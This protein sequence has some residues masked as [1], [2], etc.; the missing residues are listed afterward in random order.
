MD[1]NNNFNNNQNNNFNNN[2]N[3]NFNNNLNLSPE[4]YHYLNYAY[5][6]NDKTLETN[7]DYY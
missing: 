4:F 5:Q 2:Q 1:Y 7:L 3:N 6:S